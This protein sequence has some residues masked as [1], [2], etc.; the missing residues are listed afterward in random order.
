MRTFLATVAL[1][2]LVLTAC[3]SS[4][5]GS[6]GSGATTTAASGSDALAAKAG[7][8]GK[9]NTEGSGVA[10]AKAG[11]IEVELDDFYFGPAFVNAT[12]GTS[13]KVEVKNEG[14]ATHTF[15]IDALKIDQTIAPGK[16]VDVTVAVP[17]AGALAM[18]CRFHKGS[19]MQGAIFATS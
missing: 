11:K 15:T 3:G 10:T 7:L 6:D 4:S 1:A 9:V 16:T 19:G 14:K 13:L 2:A 17:K 18:Y 12:L 8:S 5:G